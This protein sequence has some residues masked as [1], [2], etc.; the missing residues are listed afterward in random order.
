MFDLAREKGIIYQ[1][2][3]K[4]YYYNGIAKKMPNDEIH[5]LPFEAKNNE[6]APY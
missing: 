6:E 3:R 2:E 4:K 1:N 5:K